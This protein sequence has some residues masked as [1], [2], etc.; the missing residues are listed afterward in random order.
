MMFFFF[1]RMLYIFACIQL[2]TRIRLELITCSRGYRKQRST[3][4][5]EEAFSNGHQSTYPCQEP[6]QFVTDSSTAEQNTKTF[7]VNSIVFYFCPP[8]L[9][10]IVHYSHTIYL[11]NREIRLKKRRMLFVIILVG[12]CKIIHIS[13]SITA[14]HQQLLRKLLRQY[15]LQLNPQLEKI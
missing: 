8:N 4:K 6:C 12:V 13:C 7:S 11:S 5:D 14:Q 10:P 3:C 15:S 9:V 2:T 1:F